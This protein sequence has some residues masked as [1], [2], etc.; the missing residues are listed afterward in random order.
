M[1]ESTMEK[2][3][4]TEKKINKNILFI[5]NLFKYLADRKFSIVWF[6]FALCLI[7]S[8]FGLCDKHW[9]WNICRIGLL[10]FLG[11]FIIFLYHK[12]LNVVYGLIGTKGHI[13]IYLILLVVINVIFSLIYQWGVFSKAGITY[14]INQPYIAYNMFLDKEEDIKVIH[15]P[16][17]KVPVYNSDGMQISYWVQPGEDINFQRIKGRDILKNTLMTSLMQEPS[18]FFAIASTYNQGVKDFL[19]ETKLDQQKSELFHWLLILQ[20]FISWIFFGV[21]ISILYNK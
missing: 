2:E 14:D 6:F 12:P 17:V 21:F 7:L 19:T 4:P 20:V 9:A 10:F 18:D 5:L 8:L 3:M 16:D 11:C 1:S 13:R 15:K